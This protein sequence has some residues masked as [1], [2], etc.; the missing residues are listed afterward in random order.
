MDVQTDRQ[1]DRRTDRVRRNMR[2]PPRE[3]GRIIKVACIFFLRRGLV[4]LGV[5]RV[6]L[7]ITVDRHHRWTQRLV[8]C[9]GDVFRYR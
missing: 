7:S 8:C 9:V 2:P 5:L 6:S 4:P 3:E 1:T